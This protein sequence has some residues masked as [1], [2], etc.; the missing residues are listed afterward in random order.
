MH[1]YTLKFILAI[2]TR[3]LAAMPLSFEQPVGTFIRDLK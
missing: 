1:V 2:I 3:S